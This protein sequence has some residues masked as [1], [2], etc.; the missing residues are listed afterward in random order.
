MRCD[1]IDFKLLVTFDQ[2]LSLPST[3]IAESH[4]HYGFYF[5]AL[6]REE[7]SEIILG[8]TCLIQRTPPA[9]QIGA[10]L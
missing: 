7:K 5:R 10:A 8:M 6:R 4:R 1:A 3:P 2:V 9:A